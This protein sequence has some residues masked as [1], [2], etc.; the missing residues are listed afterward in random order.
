MARTRAASA[1]ASE[2]VTSPLHK[3]D[4]HKAHRAAKS[5]LNH[6]RS[7]NRARTALVLGGGAPNMALMAGAVAAF[8]DRGVVFDVVSASG[9]GSLAGLLWLA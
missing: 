2:Q 7:E 5:Q 3:R 1:M 4:R 8:V 6:E 9:A